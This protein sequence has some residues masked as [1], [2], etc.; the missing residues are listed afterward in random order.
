MR[1]LKGPHVCTFYALLLSF[2][3]GYTISVRSIR[4]SQVHSLYFHRV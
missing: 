1:F 2:S 4:G 3:N